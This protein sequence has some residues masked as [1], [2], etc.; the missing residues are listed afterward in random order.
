PLADSR[1]TGIDLL[2]AAHE[3]NDHRPVLMPI[4]AGDEE[5]WFGLVEVRAPLLALHEIDR[6]LEVPG[7][8]GFIENSHVFDWWLLRIDKAF[9]AEVMDILD[10]CPD[11]A[12]R[13]PLARRPTPETLLTY[14]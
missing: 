4:E 13:G 12:Q 5:F 2:S 8:L 14:L 10:E 7:P 9:V 6:L 3:T 11:L 1:L